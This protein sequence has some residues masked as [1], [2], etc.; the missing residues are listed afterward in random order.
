MKVVIAPDKFKGTFSA[1]DIADAIETGIKNNFPDIETVKIPMADGGEGTIEILAQKTKAQVITLKISDPLFREIESEYLL[2]FESKTAYIESADSCGL[3]L[4]NTEEQNPMKTTSYGVGQMISDAIS[5]KTQKI[6][7]GLGGTSVNDA[8]IGLAA[9]LGFRFFENN[10][11]IKFPK[12]ENL[13][14]ITHFTFPENTSEIRNIKF[15]VLADVQIPLHGKTGA[16]HLFAAQKGASPAETEILDSGLKNFD[17]IVLHQIGENISKI[18]GS[19]SGGGLGAGCI[20]FLNAKICSG[21]HFVAEKLN[22]EQYIAESDC[23]ITGEGKIDRQSLFGK[24]I[25]EIIRLALKH[26]KKVA[27]ICAIK[28]LSDADESEFNLSKL[29]ILYEKPYNT[30]VYKQK[31]IKLIHEKT[32][33]IINELLI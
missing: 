13:T 25:S 16:A 15:T 7:I 4:L 3:M 20:V 29:K 31:T 10:E 24:T 11:E 23:V 30:I 6:I 5:K 28:D 2:D 27:A 1:T 21:A 9:A 19:G 33:E 32:A 22:L 26:K 8:G 18:P 14:K 17:R 12:G